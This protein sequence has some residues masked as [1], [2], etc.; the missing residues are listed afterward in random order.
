MFNKS[1]NIQIE[2]EYTDQKGNKSDFYKL[3]GNTSQD[4][5]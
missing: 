2:E 5:S 4:V 3:I 1:W